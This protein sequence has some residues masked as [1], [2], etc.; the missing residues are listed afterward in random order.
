MTSALNGNCTAD[1]ASHNFGPLI[2]TLGWVEAALAIK[3]VVARFLVQR[4]VVGKIEW[5]DYVMLFALVGPVPISPRGTNSGRLSRSSILAWSLL[6]S[7]MV[8]E[9]IRH[10]SP[11]KT[12]S[13]R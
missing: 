4:F 3:V 1:L 12:A 6:H 2:G 9:S 10:A 11:P 13:T 7:T 5:N 8:W